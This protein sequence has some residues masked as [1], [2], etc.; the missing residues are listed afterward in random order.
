LDEPAIAQLL[1]KL[2]EPGGFRITLNIVEPTRYW[3]Q[4]TEVNLGLTVWGHRPLGTMALALGYTADEQGQP[5]AWNETHWVD[6]E[7]T[8]LLRQ[9][10]RTLDV[11]TR[12]EIMCQIEDIMQSRGPIG[13]SYW[14]RLWNITRTEFRNVKAHPAGYDLFYDV[15]K[16]EGAAQSG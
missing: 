15:W 3:E 5:V 11:P 8:T 13:I 16:D 6:E 1:Q 9:A 12:R 4:W 10:E 7:F 14:R 2:A